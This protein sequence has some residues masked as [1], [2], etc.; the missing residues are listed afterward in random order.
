MYGDNAN[1][2]PE[3]IP[4]L[5]SYMDEV[6]PDKSKDDDPGSTMQDI[7]I[8]ADKYLPKRHREKKIQ[9]RG[10]HKFYKKRNEQMFAL[11]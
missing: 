8:D 6:M 4:E 2:I 5:L 10:F 7:M 1:I 11:V 9:I 3:E